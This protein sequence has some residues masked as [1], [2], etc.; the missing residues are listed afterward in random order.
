MKYFVKFL[1]IVFQLPKM[2]F[3]QKLIA[4]T[5]FAGGQIDRLLGPRDIP[6]ATRLILLN[7]LYFKA[8]WLN[9]FNPRD[10][11]PGFFTTSAGQRVPTRFM[12][13]R[14]MGRLRQDRDRQEP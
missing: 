10:T 1:E 2:L 14:M 13:L 5:L 11:F 8:L 3:L 7:A 9:R 12:S 4:T 6:P